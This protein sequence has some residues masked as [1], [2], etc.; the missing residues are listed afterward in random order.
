MLAKQKW[1]YEIYAVNEHGYSEKVS[2]TR[3]ATTAAAKNPGRPGSLLA[4]Q[5]T[6]ADSRIVNLYWTKPDAGGQE[7][8]GYEIEVTDKSNRWP[9][10]QALRP[11]VVARLS[12]NTASGFDSNEGLLAPDPGDSTSNPPNVAVIVIQAGSQAAPAVDNNEPFQ[13]QHTYTGVDGDFARTLH[14]RVRTIT[15][16]G[17]GEKKSTSYTS[18]SVAIAFDTDDDTGLVGFVAPIL[19]PLVGADAASTGA[20]TD[21]DEDGANDGDVD[22]T[23]A[24][25]RLHT[26]HETPGANGYRVDVSTDNG[27]TWVTH[28][29]AS[30]PINEYDY[31]GSDVKPGKKYRFRLFSK[32]GDHGL[33][34]AVVQDYAGPSSAPGPARN[35][36]AS[37]DGAGKID[38]SWTAPISDNGA[39]I[40]TY[41]IVANQNGDLDNYRGD[42][43]GLIDGDGDID[44]IDDATD[45]LAANCTRFG[46]PD[47]SPISIKD[48]A[49]G[50]FQ[51]SGSTTSVSFSNVLS[52]TQWYFEVYGLNGATGFTDC[53]ETRRL[54]QPLKLV[55][56]MTVKG[57]T[58]PPILR[59]LPERPG[60]LTAEDARDT[61]FQG[62]GKQGVLVLWTAP[63][64]PAGA[65]VIG[66]K[67]ER[68]IDDGDFVT[69]VDNLNTGDTHW[70]D[71]VE[72][73]M[74]QTRVYRVASINSVDVGTAT[75][76]ATIPLAEH[77]THT[78]P[79]AVGEL[80]APER[81]CGDAW[82]RNGN[83]RVDIG[84]EHGR[85]PDHAV[86]R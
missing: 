79:P 30:R 42:G 76:M 52:E 53:P 4:L 73:P 50:V 17:S 11:A 19:A 18:D 25:L 31:R 47:K 21:Q 71:Q 2:A 40:D 9:S 22:G 67:I 61:N 16:I 8:T 60:H 86:H 49:E 70:V 72:L 82:N 35:L 75:I 37:A 27:A 83:G 32:K 66:Y 3:N 23:P 10:A 80:T 1:S 28:E 33:A 57:M 58:P 65:P 84:R 14:Y 56:P 41:C 59:W 7:I 74:D 5:V 78:T 81:H 38:L 34:S 77:T 55:W 45:D 6:N 13:L 26:S 29:T 68:S 15:G 24:E 62:V 46:A 36:A 69:M 64:N 44:V 20:D 54:L 51:V 12:D 39:M 85:A 48:M 43:D 63:S